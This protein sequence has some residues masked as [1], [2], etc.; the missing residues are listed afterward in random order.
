M[1]GSCKLCPDFEQAISNFECKRVCEPGKRQ[2]TDKSCKPCK[3][4]QIVTIDG[5]DC[6]DC[7]DYHVISADFSKCEKTTCA[8]DDFRS[9]IVNKDGDCVNC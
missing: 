5:L 8:K 6:Q 9:K 1:D 2:I 4:T 7:P 3:P